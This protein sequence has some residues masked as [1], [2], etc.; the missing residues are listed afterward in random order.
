MLAIQ[1]LVLF[2][3]SCSDWL[4]IQIIFL[5][6]FTIPWLLVIIE[7]VFSSVQN[8]FVV[9]EFLTQTLTSNVMILILK[10]RPAGRLVFR[11]P[12]LLIMPS[13]R[14]KI[15]FLSKQ[16]LF[17]LGVLFEEHFSEETL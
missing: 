2:I 11:P 9:L 10:K 7:F 3:L 16:L 6:V 8:F 13:I 17:F 15:R 5:G 1:L 14:K 4:V 12:I